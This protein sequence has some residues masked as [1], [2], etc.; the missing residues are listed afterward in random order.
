[1][2]YTWQGVSSY[3]LVC[4][5]VLEGSQLASPLAC[6]AVFTQLFNGRLAFEFVLDDQDNPEAER[7]LEQ[8]NRL[9][10]VGNSNDGAQ[11]TVQN[12]SPSTQ[13]AHPT[14]LSGFIRG[15]IEQVYLLQSDLVSRATIEV[16]NLPLYR[17]HDIQIL[18]PH[19]SIKIARTLD[20]KRVSQLLKG[21]NCAGVIAEISI[22]FS[23]AL[24]FNEVDDVIRKL[25]GLLGLAQRSHVSP[26]VIRLYDYAGTLLRTKYEEPVF[27][28]H[29]AA[30]PL[31][32]EESLPEFIQ[33]AF[34]LPSSLYSEWQ[35]GQAQ[36]YY[37]QAAALTSAWSQAIGFFTALETIKAAYIEIVGK[38][39]SYVPRNQFK[40]KKIADK[41]LALL[42]QEFA[43]YEDLLDKSKL[44][45]L[46]AEEQEE[47]KF[48]IQ[49]LKSKVGELNRPAY[50][51]VLKSMFQYLG[52]TV[53]SEELNQLVDLRNQIIHSGSPDYSK[54]PWNNPTEAHRQVCDFAG[55]VERTIL[56]IIKYSG[57]V[58]TYE[59]IVTSV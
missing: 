26:V 24:K 42:S 35:L 33:A 56:A 10:F 13:H 27:D 3:Q 34:A 15:P 36:D 45:T 46:S 44:S 40:N 2:Y 48:E 5:G 9:S 43:E 58:I 51:L 8:P 59:Q 31:I 37:I 11:I 7:W 21:I 28:I 20:Y 57:P 19:G 22:D 29:K 41:V 47:R 50:K 23:E 39:D 49:T 25:C 18:T 16:T 54:G 52:V 53:A 55:L 38:F 30:Q 1:M 6:S 14:G 4:Q 17:M 12:I 32:P